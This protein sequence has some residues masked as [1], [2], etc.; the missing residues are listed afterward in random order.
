MNSYPYLS[1]NLDKIQHN[2]R[3]IVA[4]CNKFGIEVT[5]VTKV[6]CG[7]PEIA[8]AMLRGGVS[9]LADSRL[10]NIQR[11]KDAAIQT[12]L[13]LLRIPPLSAVE[14]V[15]ELTDISLN[16]ELA[17]LEGLSRAAQNHNKIHDVIIMVDLGDLREGILP[18]EVIPFVDEV[19]KL[20]GINIQG[21]GTNLACFSGVEPSKE[22]M[23]QLVDLVR[24][25]E[26][27]FNIKLEKLSAINS[28]GLEL[29]A[30]GQM[31]SPINHARIGE[32]IL[33]GRETLHRKP[34]P[35]TYQDAFM[36]HGEVLEQ[37]HKPSAP[38]GKR[39]QDAFGEQP[40]FDDKG[41]RNRILVNVGR[42]DMDIHGISPLDTKLTIV[43]ASSGYLVVDATDSEKQYE[44]GDEIS[45]AVNYSALLTAMTSEYVKKRF[46][47]GTQA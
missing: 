23:Q 1:I 13:M 30:S 44:V 8:K 45:L 34:W 11:L 31:P 39:S 29:I 5:G 37:K 27:T 35:N 20:P 28:S 25:I 32:A 17:V 36:L 10:E 38:A 40:M 42:E 21:I 46:V 47:G 43:G 12:S 33:L 24:T 16:S 19:I 18:D 26:K 9:S 7:C 41:L 6:V 2:T 3:S 4:L 14:Q 15:V 22:N